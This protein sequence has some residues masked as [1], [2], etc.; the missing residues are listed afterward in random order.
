GHPARRD[1]DAGNGFALA[2]AL[3]QVADMAVAGQHAEAGAQVL[4]DG[5]CLG[6][7]LDDDEIEFSPGIARA[8]GRSTG[9]PL[10]GRDG[11]GGGVSRCRRRLLLPSG[12]DGG[13]VVSGL[14]L[15]CGHESVP[16][17]SCVTERTRY[18][19]YFGPSPSLTHTI[20]F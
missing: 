15:A 2:T 9:S 14:L 16:G 10:A 13:C 7:R 5:L 6:R 4:V 12:C 11:S 8:G 3:R 18:N 20:A 1:V 17:C 19:R